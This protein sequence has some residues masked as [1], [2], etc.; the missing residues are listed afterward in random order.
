MI[1]PEFI[2]IGISVVGGIFVG[3][4]AWSDSKAATK[5]NTKAID[6]LRQ[7]IDARIEAHIKNDESVE[8]SLKNQVNRLWAW[9]DLNVKETAE[10]R[11]QNQKS[12]S[13]ISASVAVQ[14]S[15]YG[16][17]KNMITSMGEAITKKIDQL[18]SKLDRS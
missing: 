14:G 4:Y 13:D 16:E 15:Q 17:L 12:L 9:K 10:H 5:E 18:E 2:T 8:E 6:T 1:S 7:A 11:L 3:G